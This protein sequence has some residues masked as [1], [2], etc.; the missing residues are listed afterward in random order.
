MSCRASCFEGRSDCEKEFR[1]RNQPLM[2][3]DEKSKWPRSHRTSRQ[4]SPG[5]GSQEVWGYRT[6]CF[7]GPNMASINISIRCLKERR[8][9]AAGWWVPRLRA[10]L[11]KMTWDSTMLTT[12]LRGM[13][14]VWVDGR[15]KRKGMVKHR[16]REDF[17][18]R[19]WWTP[20]PQ[21]FT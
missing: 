6:N 10:A 9:V 7:W 4:A 3:K 1:D 13:C 17:G 15:N 5:H 18:R 11:E 8:A 20:C 19:T 12:L 2:G 21:L 14:E 16:C